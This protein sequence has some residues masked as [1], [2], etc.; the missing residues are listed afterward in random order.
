[1]G[2]R[3]VK[4]LLSVTLRIDKSGLL[5]H[6]LG[7]CFTLVKLWAAFLHS[8]GRNEVMTTSSCMQSRIPPHLYLKKD[9]GCLCFLALRIP[10]REQLL[11]FEVLLGSA[12]VWRWVLLVYFP[13]VPAPRLTG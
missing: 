5:V 11:I 2:V 10:C 9:F 8:S 12:G 7:F 4:V 6:R 13:A 3:P 1:M